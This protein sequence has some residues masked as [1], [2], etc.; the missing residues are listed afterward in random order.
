MPKAQFEYS[1]GGVVRDA[2]GRF[3]VVETTDLKGNVVWTFPKGLLK[4]G[5]R[6][7][8]AALRE[9]EEETGYR[10]RI[11]GELPKAEYWFRHGGQLVKKTVR[12]FLM[13]PVE[14]T[15]SH[16]WEVRSVAWLTPEEALARLTYASDR[17]L[18]HAALGGPEGTP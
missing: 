7:Q 17:D 6:S 1:A 11:L 14:Q 12:W 18:V 15:G 4:E 16:D 2:E 10:C 13:E 3:L 8:E 9:V 5:E